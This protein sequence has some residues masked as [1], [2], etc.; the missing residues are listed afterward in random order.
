MDGYITYSEATAT[1]AKELSALVPRLRSQLES[2]SDQTKLDGRGPVFLGIGASLAAAASAVWHLR[3]RGF[4][5]SR[6]DP[7]ES[8]L[9][10][11]VGTSPVFAVSQSGRSTETIAS[12]ESVE[13]RRRFA[14][15][16][17]SPSPLSAMACDTVELGNI[18]D[19]YASTI[20]FTATV[21]ALG[22]LAEAWGGGTPRKDWDTLGVRLGTFE[23]QVNEESE[24]AAELFARTASADFVGSATSLGSAELGALLFRE[25]TRIPSTAMST[26]QY[27]HGAMESAGEGV[28]VLL[29]NEREYQAALMLAG[30][31]H[32]VILVTD[33]PMPSD[34]GICMIAIPAVPDTERGV[35]EARVLQQLAQKVARLR[36]IDIEEF[37][38]HNS[39]TKLI[40][41]HSL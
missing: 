29:G 16:N 17:V 12:F 33:T 25:V 9:P 19:S 31:G 4:E 20:G 23:S 10:I 13:P 34:P 7:G 30:A 2:L 6:M 40:K 3:K 39:D 28:H 36:G 32:P 15:V 37:V 27:L 5:A 41:E 11:T 1:Q 35:F 18:D 24:R 38:F 21:T 26:R 22:M 8:P 14:I